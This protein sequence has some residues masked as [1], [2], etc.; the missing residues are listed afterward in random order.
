MR[1][2]TPKFQAKPLLSVVP[3]RKR[4][5]A[6]V[7]IEEVVVLAMEVVALAVEKSTIE[8]TRITSLVLVEF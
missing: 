6:S 4:I 5:L 8:S 3:G 7:K 1:K 2:S